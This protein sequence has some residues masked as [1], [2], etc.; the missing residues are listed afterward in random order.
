MSIR[1]NKI[2]RGRFGNKVFQYNNLVQMANNLGVEASCIKWEGNEF[3]KNIVSYKKTNKKQK[4]LY[5]N[6]ILEMSNDNLKLLCNDYD[7]ILDDPSYALHNT[8]YKLTNKDPRNYLELK[9]K[10][11]PLLPKNNT[12]V[13]IHIRGGD[14]KGRDR[15][16]GRE[17]HTP[18][19]YKNS[20]KYLLDHKENKI[21]N[22][23]YH[24]IIC[25]DDIYFQSTLDTI[26]F[27]KENKCNFSMG[28]N[29]GSLK[30]IEDFA[31]LC[32]SDILINSSSTFC[33]AAVFIGK[34]NKKIIFSKDW[35]D[36]VVKGDFSNE[37]YKKYIDHN[38]IL[39]N[40]IDDTGWLTKGGYSKGK[41]FFI[42]LNKNKYFN[43]LNLV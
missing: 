13:G 1:I 27:L 41:Y 40:N 14:I 17:I 34:K 30:Y 4:I 31:T 7:L 22:M 26:K 12:I 20:I 16:G 6:E 9:D 19:Y 32:Y 24:F 28:P 18:T 2:T 8:F 39:E 11:V 42:D 36:R 38:I 43:I 33:C 3:F 15:Q 35:M 23:D 5:W 25:T 37:E 10:Y 21:N 29:F